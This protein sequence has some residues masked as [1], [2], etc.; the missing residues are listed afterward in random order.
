MRQAQVPLFPGSTLGPYEILAPLGA[1]GMGEVYRARDPRLGREVA[2]KVLPGERMADEDRRRRFVRE[3]RA[4][5]AL[6]HPNI[7]TIHE[8]DS[9]DGVDFIVME[10]VA[11]KTLDHLIP[12]QGMRL[13]KVLRVA[14]P[15]ADAL[16]RAHGAGIVHR[17]LKPANVAVTPEGTVKV[18]DFGLA[19]L[20]Q[21]E[22][23]SEEAEAVTED[24]VA[25]EAL[26]RPG[27]VAGTAGY[28]SPEQASGGKVDARSDVF[29]FGSVLYE[30]VTGQRAF[31]RSS[32]VETLAAVIKEQPKSPSDLVPGVPRELERVIERCLRKE[33]ERRF[34][35]MLDVKVELQEVKEESDSVAVAAAP[36]GRWR[37]KAW[38]AAGLAGVA[39]A[40][41]LAAWHWRPREAP[42][43]PP[44]VE[45]L[46]A[47]R[48]W[49]SSPTFSPDGQQ[50]AFAWDGE[51]SDNG[52]I[53]V[54]MI[55]SSE[56]HRLTTDPKF[57]AAPSWSP[58]GRQIA[59]L[60]WSSG[61]ATIHLVSPLGG[62]ARKLIDA[63]WEGPLS[64]SPDG[65]WLAAVRP[66]SENAAT[67]GA[68]GVW[69]VPVQG[70][71]PR[72]VTEP[73]PE[74]ND[75]APA[76]SPDGLRLAYASCVTRLPPSPCDVHVLAVGPDFVPTGPSRR[77]TRQGFTI[78]GF[79]WAR[80]GASLVYDTESG[81]ST[82]HLWRVG[83]EG[84]QPPERL[85]VAGM[86]ALDPAIAASGSRLAFSRQLQ[87]TDIV[88][89]AAERPPEVALSSSFYEGSSRFSPD[90]RRVAFESV[91]SGER[92]EIWLA[93]ADG[94]NPVQ[95]TRGPGRWQGSPS[96]SPDGRR[97]VFDSQGEDG[98]WDLWTIDVDGGAPR[99][100]TQ[101]P[102]DENVP[103]WS[104]DGRWVYFTS[105]RDGAPG[106]WRVP[107]DGGTEESV[108]RT[109]AWFGV[110]ESNDGQALFFKRE[111]GRAPLV[112][113]PLAGG[114]DRTLVDC[115]RGNPGF[116]VAAAAIYY[117]ACGEG[118]DPDLH[119]LD[120]A[121][122]Q[123]R[124]LGRLEKYMGAL[125]VSPDGRTILYQ[126]LARDEADLMLI[127][128]FR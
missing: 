82:F 126:K 113:R 83:I 77:L 124:R 64:W 120:L 119:R 7:V 40:S 63:P 66:R 31:S 123:D 9:V 88:S 58:D 84:D 6:N 60:R 56:V 19:K 38:I 43:P 25:A 47:T 62:T 76:F 30:M 2:I 121:N 24:A 91:R 80:D 32:A 21:Q 114:P 100:L 74:G 85:E 37:R 57:E 93:A 106:I 12:Q 4:A 67:E 115:V 127:E 102:G 45:P 11:G 107:A 1:G 97:I 52:D 42:L 108:A 14:I 87:D 50:V 15:M 13:D 65:R 94:T 49:E 10:L 117:A 5:S 44:H 54:K 78:F 17:D 68:G 26:S 116:A 122:G 75:R 71:E 110:E 109:G 35:H 90:G 41:A 34:Q 20:L 70:G 16:A 86:G 53:Y 99:K 104:R 111:P 61:N 101:H 81:P 39:A 73:Q 103:R 125:T 72:R 28:M 23:A 79:A 59:F 69:L 118:G 46:T 3:A 8:I 51:K 95:L 22:L 98:R 48:G 112:A 36:A 18:L 27:T 92:L 29:S 33:P 89:F 55:G 128:N 105:E 96:W